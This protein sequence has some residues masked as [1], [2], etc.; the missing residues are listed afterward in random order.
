MTPAGYQP[1]IPASLYNGLA[2]L[3]ATPPHSFSDII[4]SHKPTGN[5]YMDLFAEQVRKYGKRNSTWYARQMNADPRQF[6]GAIRCMSGM[7]THDW[8][9]EYMRLVACDLIEQTDWT[10]KEISKILGLSSSSF[11]QFFRASQRMQPWEY[12]SLKKQGRKRSY[13]Y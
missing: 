11:S 10:F 9:N 1:I 8:I 2:E 12:R 5:N 13:F 4:L 3:P 6:D 7:S